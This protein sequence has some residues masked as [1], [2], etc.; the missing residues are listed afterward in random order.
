MNKK[1]F[2]DKFPAK[3]RAYTV[4]AGP[5]NPRPNDG[6]PVPTQLGKLNT[7]IRRGCSGLVTPS[8]IYNKLAPYAAVKPAK[9][10]WR[11]PSE[12]S[13]KERQHWH[14]LRKHGLL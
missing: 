4:P 5:V 1:H 9:V 10:V 8:S 3:P 13:K 14:W 12:L 7:I 11:A 6:R 2:V